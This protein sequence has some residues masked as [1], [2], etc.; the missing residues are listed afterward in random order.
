[1]VGAGRAT[2]TDR[3]H[4][5]AR[6][7]PYLVTP[8]N[9]RVERYIYG[10]ALQ[11]CGMVAATEPT[12]IQ[13]ALK[14]AGTLTEEAIKNGSLKKSIEKR[15]VK[16]KTI[17]DIISNRSFME[18]LFRNHYVLVK[19]V[20]LNQA[21]RLGGG[22]PNQVVAINEGQGCRNNGN[23]ARGRAFILGAEE[24]HQDPNIMTGIE[25]SNLGFSYEIEIASDSYES[26]DVI[27]GM[28]WLS[29]H[30]AEIICQNF[31]K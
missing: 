22:H 15:D 7:V 16:S 24:A 2:Y 13:K 3:F 21:Q 8:E 23:R 4:E 28:D 17:E 14:K 20:L 1:M 30:K 9:K 26:F 6:L 27:I 25:S 29:K 31:P 12:T 11:I 18:A 19:N 5:L 10:L